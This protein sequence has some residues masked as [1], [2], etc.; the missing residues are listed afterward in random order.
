MSDR[1]PMEKVYHIFEVYDYKG[2]ELSSCINLTKDEFI[3]RLIYKFEGFIDYIFDSGKFDDELTDEDYDN[4]EYGT[5]SDEFY[6]KFR[7]IENLSNYLNNNCSEY[8]GCG[9]VFELYKTVD[10]ELLSYSLTDDDFNII[11]NNMK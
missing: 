3:N 2:G 9:D 11:I 10:N 4:C 6:D 7:T 5:L 8:A 1:I